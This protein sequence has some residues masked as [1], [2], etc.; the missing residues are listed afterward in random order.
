M[1]KSILRD[2]PPTAVEELAPLLEKLFDEDETDLQGSA[3]VR[4]QV[5][6]ETAQPSS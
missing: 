1:K 3:E 6:P 2:L 5:P 4:K